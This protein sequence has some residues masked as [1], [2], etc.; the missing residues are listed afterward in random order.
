MKANLLRTAAPALLLATLVLVPFHDKA[1]TI[2]DTLFLKQA[3]HVLSDPLHPT[4]FETAWKDDWERVSTILPTGPVMAWLLVPSALAGGS[5]SLAH[6]VELALLLLAIIASV[7]LGLRLGLSRGWACAAG[8]LV[9][10]MPAVLG[11]AGTAMPDVPALAF[12]VMGLERLVAWRQDRRLPSAALAALLLGLAVLT[13]THLLLLLGVGALLV[14]DDPFSVDGWRRDLAPRLAPLAAAPLLTAALM[15]LTADPAARAGSIGGSAARY[16][17]LVHLGPNAVAFAT[18]WVLAMIFALP[19]AVLRWRPLL[20]RAWVFVA[21]SIA[22]ALVFRL[23][24]VPPTPWP[25][26]LV[27]GLGAAVLADVLADAVTRRDGLQLALVLWLVFPLAVVPYVHFPSKYLVPSAPAAAILLARE[28]AKHARLARPL[29]VASLG[30]GV[31]L[32]VAILRADA[33]FAGVD[34]TAAAAVIAPQVAAGRNVWF[35][36]HWGF[37]WYAEQAGARFFAVTPPF[38]KPG[39]VVVASRGCDPQLDMYELQNVAT[40][41]GRIENREPG[42]RIMDRASG[43]G[44]YSNGS[45]FLPWSWGDGILEAVDVWQFVQGPPGSEGA[46]HAA[47]EA[48]AP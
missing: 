30:L 5:E 46:A 2:D 23:A 37:Q 12:G 41:I 13:R 15:L 48:H 40:R 34:R 38:P 21:A 39:D 19:W 33:A 47:T 24:E 42:G 4:A 1:F 25:L 32:G 45:G 20:R 3:T 44:F 31:S 6:A 35:I 7:S 29:L 36:G 18:H 43:A 22:A 14:V 11:M 16:S 8:L 26:A 17:G 10:S 27:A 9:A 28:L